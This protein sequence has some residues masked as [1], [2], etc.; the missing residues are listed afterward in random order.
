MP[1]KGCFR[2]LRA[3]KKAKYIF[4]CVKPLEVK[5]ILMEIQESLTKGSDLQS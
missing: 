4:I 2:D 5:N 3:A 1:E